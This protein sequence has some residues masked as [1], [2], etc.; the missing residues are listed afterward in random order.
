MR[1]PL[2]AEFKF[3]ERTTGDFAVP[4]ML[5]FCLDGGQRGITGSLTCTFGRGTTGGL[6]GYRE[7]PDGQKLTS[8]RRNMQD[9]G[10]SYV[11]LFLG[12]GGPRG[13]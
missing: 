13:H 6:Q 8:V 1:D 3:R 11:F 2:H 12:G 5:I 7:V 10:V 4:Y 9:H